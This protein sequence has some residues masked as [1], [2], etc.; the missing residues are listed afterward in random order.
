M[1]VGI[2]TLIFS[3]VLSQFYRAF[4]A[5]L[6][7][8]LELEL[9]ASKQDLAAA[10]GWWF[11]AFAALQLPVGTAFDKFGPR[12]TTAAC[13]AL[14]AIG[15]ATFAT[16]TGPLQIKIAMALIG[17]GCAPILMA[18]YFIFARQFSPAL[19]GTLAG[20]TVGIGS[21]G[22]ILGSLPL[23][24]LAEAFGWRSAIW[25]MAA[26]TAVVALCTLILVQ[27]PERLETK[28]A[29]SVWSVLAMPQLWP[30]LA[31]M[32]VCYAAPSALR[33]LWLGPYFHDV[34]G[35]DRVE[36]GWAG[37]AMGL[38]LVVGSLVIGPIG[39]ALG[40]IKWV[41]FG[42]NL[43]LVLAVTALWLRIFDGATAQLVLFVAAG[44]FGS[45]FPMVTAHARGF[46]PPA[47]MGRGVTL[48]NLCGILPV[49]IAQQVTGRLHA[50]LE[51]A[52]DPA[53]PFTAVFGYFALTTA[54]GLAIYL[55]S[56]ERKA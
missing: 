27:D 14:A 11:I 52:A 41:V 38:G 8:I 46:I 39:R 33:G 34:W 43:I 13:L 12:R 3:Y 48:V 31:M 40:T 51:G 7:P 24:M 55:I 45:T 32:L 29:G 54:V 28:G 15:A 5:V 37:M 42:S 16:A 53:T 6:T 49:G 50:G 35:F 47:V 21:M 10:S 56:T 18:S 20:I 19:F 9:G 44:V 25:G 2:A 1:R 30:V 23:A 4:L 26:V 36:V 22:D 17:A